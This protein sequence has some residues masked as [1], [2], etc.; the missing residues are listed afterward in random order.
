MNLKFSLA[1]I[2]AHWEKL[3]PHFKML[4]EKTCALQKTFNVRNKVTTFGLII[5]FFGLILS[6]PGY[7]CSVSPLFSV[8]MALTLVGMVLILFPDK[9]A[10]PVKA[11]N[12][13]ADMLVQT[14][15]SYENKSFSDSKS[16]FDVLLSNSDSAICVLLSSQR[17][18]SGIL[19]L[20]EDIENLK[21]ADVLLSEKI[22]DYTYDENTLK[23]RYTDA[24]GYVHELQTPCTRRLNTEVDMPSLYYND[25]RFTL[26]EKYQNTPN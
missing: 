17:T 15:E 7:F 13:D 14:L 25:G 12:H 2:D 10:V 20:R 5:T 26:V 22:L 16:S 6:I 4:R 24:E 19:L 18:K 3:R 21:K 11:F 9:I 8:G 1:D 23:I